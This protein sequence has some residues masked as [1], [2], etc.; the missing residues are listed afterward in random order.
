VA[1]D[2]ERGLAVPVVKECQNKS[3]LDIALELRRL[4]ALVSQMKYIIV[5][6]IPADTL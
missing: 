6:L 2:T 4:Y 5:E 1:V 3:V